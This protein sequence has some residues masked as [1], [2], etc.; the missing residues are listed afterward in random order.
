[1]TKLTRAA[2][3]VVPPSPAELPVRQWVM[4]DWAFRVQSSWRLQPF[5]SQLLAP[6]ILFAAY[7]HL[8]SRTGPFP[9]MM[10]PSPPGLK[11]IT[12]LPL[13]PL[14]HISRSP[15]RVMATADALLDSAPND[16]SRA[17]LLTASSKE[18]RAWLNALPISSD[19]MMRLCVWQLASTWA[20]PSVGLIPA[21]TVELMSLTLGPMA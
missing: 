16:L 9:A 17:C 5:W 7:F 1:M 8:T 11:T 15:I 2:S 6:L 19:W 20:H 4:V 14:A 12:S 10:I 13:M 3:K 21:P 18:A